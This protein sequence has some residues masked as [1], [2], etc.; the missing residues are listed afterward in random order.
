LLC[1]DDYRVRE[2]VSG[3]QSVS[4]VNINNPSKKGIREKGDICIVGRIGGM[5]RTV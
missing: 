3:F 1:S 4:K 5:V 2:R